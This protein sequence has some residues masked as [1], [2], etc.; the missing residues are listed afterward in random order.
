MKVLLTGGSGF[1][2]TNLICSLIKNDEDVLNID[3]EKP[4]NPSHF[5]NWVDCN[6]LDY[7]HMVQIASNFKPDILINLAAE[8]NLVLSQDLAAYQANTQGVSNVIKLCKDR[9]IGKAIFFSSMLVHSRTSLMNGLNPQPDT[10]YGR[11]KLLGEEIVFNSKLSNVCEV[12]VLRPTS[13]WGPWF[14]APYDQF[15]KLGSKKILIF[16]DMKLATKT[17]GYVENT[18]NQVLSVIYGSVQFDQT[19]PIYLAD[20]VPIE[21]SEFLRKIREVQGLRKI[22]RIPK[23]FFYLAAKFGDVLNKR[24]IKF[25]LNSYRWQNLIEDRIV[26]TDEILLDKCPVSLERGIL[27]TIEWSQ[28]NKKGLFA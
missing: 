3:I 26:S 6:V 5:V 21:I 4:R 13:I 11:S 2:G 1:I 7:E 28:E 12:S 20:Q 9:K 10:D 8:T 23:N 15:F 25:P 24:D 27:N 17:F 14:G 19:K 18:V 22:I 16:P